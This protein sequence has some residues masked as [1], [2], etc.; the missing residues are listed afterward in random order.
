MRTTAPRDPVVGRPSELGRYRIKEGERL[1]VG[2]RVDGVVQVT[3]RPLGRPGRTYLVEE[4]ISSKQELAAL[5]ADY[6]AQAERLGDC[7][8][9]ASLLN[10]DESDRIREALS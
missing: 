6:K 4:G 9:R 8:M 1:L 10:L 3:D 2:Q 7:P 5:I